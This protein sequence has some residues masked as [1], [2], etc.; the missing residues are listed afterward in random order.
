LAGSVT[1]N[2]EAPVRMG[3]D[4]IEVD[5]QTAAAAEKVYFVLNKKRGVVT[6]A[7][8]EHERATVYEFLPAST[9]GKE[10]GHVN[11]W[12]APVGRLDKASEGLLLMT[13]DSEWAARITAPES[14]LDKTY[15]VQIAAVAD[16]TVLRNLR[17]GI[18]SRGET[19][20][21]KRASLLRS[22]EKNSW[23]EI[24]LDEG[25]NRQIRRMLEALGIEVLRL[26]RVS[27]GPLALGDLQRG[28]VRPLTPPEKALLDRALAERAG[29]RE[30]HRTSP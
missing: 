30:K 8:D 2:P 18:D 19:L 4:R 15:H 27:I 3:I 25:K 23:I 26:I 28:A 22:G 20:A 21:A 14:H 16:D 29:S 7:S 17:N 11:S 9:T 13:N 1:R 12:I 6:S 24:V 10:A 5:G